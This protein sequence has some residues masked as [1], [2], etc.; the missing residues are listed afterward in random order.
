MKLAH[1][2]E[3]E[4]KS[5]DDM[6]AEISRSRTTVSRIRRELI[7]PDWETMERI[8]EA[9]NGEVTPNDY[10]TATEVAAE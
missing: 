1:W 2:M 5:D 6:A 7:R 3:R 8:F 9:T 4:R 10:F